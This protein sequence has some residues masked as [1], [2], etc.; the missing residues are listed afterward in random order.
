MFR[1]EGI[2]WQEVEGK[3]V[4]GKLLALYWREETGGEP[5]VI[6]LDGAPVCVDCGKE[7]PTGRRSVCYDDE[8]LQKRKKCKP[9]NSAVHMANQMGVQ[10]LS[11]EQYKQLHEIEK[12]DLKT[13]SWLQ[14]PDE[15]RMLGGAIFGDCRYDRVFIYHNGADSYYK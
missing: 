6:L 15:V 10:L 8:A 14:T 1:H 11:E 13:S 9:E 12:V 3:L 5:D 7:P 2:K 4:D